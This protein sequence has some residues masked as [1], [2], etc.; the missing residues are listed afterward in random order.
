MNSY[1][2]CLSAASVV[3]LL[4]VFC[5]SDASA[6]N[7]LVNPGFETGNFAGW[8]IAG[9]SISF[10]VNTDGTPIA[11]AQTPFPP[12]FV[13]VRS[14][15]FAGW[16]LVKDGIDPVERI[17]LTQTQAVPPN[18]LLNIGFWETIPAVF[19][20]CLLITT[21]P[22]FSSMVWEYCHSAS[23]ISRTAAHPQPLPYS[24]EPSTP[25]R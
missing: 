3:I 8:T 14:G 11:G 12:N 15:A 13:N 9:N 19:S 4:T 22:R 17:T 6:D 2:V 5:A 7:L 20:E 18:E 16:A 1:R 21:I 10:G 24:P 25:V 23:S